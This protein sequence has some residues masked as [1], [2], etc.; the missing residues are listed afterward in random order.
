MGEQGERKWH[1]GPLEVGNQKKGNEMEIYN[2]SNK[3]CVKKTNTVR[4]QCK[5][6]GIF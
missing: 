6:E 1:V 2:I 3:K 4:I 5:K